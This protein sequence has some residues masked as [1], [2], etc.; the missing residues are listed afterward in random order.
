[1]SLRER[2]RKNRCVTRRKTDAKF[3]RL[4]RA[5]ED[6]ACK[7]GHIVKAACESWWYGRFGCAM[8]CPAFR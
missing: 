5:E 3:M 4:T 7:N 1:M 2:P 8:P 6:K